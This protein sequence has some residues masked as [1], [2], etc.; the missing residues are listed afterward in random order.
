[1]SPEEIYKIVTKDKPQND[2]HIED[3]ADFADFIRESAITRIEDTLG[4]ETFAAIC[5]HEQVAV[6]D[7]R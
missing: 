4:A 7:E 3:Y 2:G 5:N 6:I 1:M